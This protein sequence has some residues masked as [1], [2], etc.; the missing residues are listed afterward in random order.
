MKSSAPRTRSRSVC[1]L[2]LLL[3]LLAAPHSVSAQSARE[4]PSPS[5]P[6]NPSDS[7]AL[8]SADLRAKQQELSIKQDSLDLM[9]QSAT[10][11]YEQSARRSD[12]LRILEQYASRL[13]VGAQSAAKMQDSLV[14]LQDSLKLAQSAEKSQK[15]E[16]QT[17]KTRTWVSASLALLFFASGFLIGGKHIP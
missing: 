9:K 1:F 15:K 16:A 13:K 5:K 8:V 2:V 17:W 10:F 3:L 12:S 4:K 11:Y 14:A 6:E 7:L